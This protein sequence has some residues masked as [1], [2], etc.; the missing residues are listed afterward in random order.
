M[1]N[2]FY[3]YNYPHIKNKKTLV[4]ELANQSFYYST[5]IKEFVE[6]KE[7]ATENFHT[8]FNALY[9]EYQKSINYSYQLD[10]FCDIY[11]Q[12]LA[13][14]LMLARLDA[15][16][17]LDE[18]SLNY[19]QDIPNEYKLLKEFLS[20][21]YV[22]YDL[23]K[24]LRHTLINIG[25]NI[26]MIDTE[27]I[28][29]EFA[30][31][32]EGKQHIAV[33]LYEDFLQEYDK[34][35]K[36]KNRKESGVYYT[37]V[38]ATNFI[39]RGVNE[40]IKTRFNM[41][42]GY[43]AESVKVLDFACG[44]GTFLH[45]VFDEMLNNVVIVG[46]DPQ[47]P[48][49]ND[50]TVDDLTREIIKNKIVND[51]YGLELLFVPYIISHT[52]L[53]RFLKEHG[54][55]LKDKER[56]GIY[57]ANTLDI[58]QHS[59]SELLPNLKK[60]YEKAMDIKSRDEILAI[61]GNP[62]YF[63][64]ISQAKKGLIDE[65]IKIYKKDLNEKNIVKLEDL[66]IK[67]I[68]FAEW[69]I[70]KQKQGVIG[71]ITNNTYLDG[72]ISRKMRKHLLET[73]D[74]IYI[75]NLHGNARRKEPDKNI[76]DVMIGV[77]IIFLVKLPKRANKKVVRYF[78]TLDNNLTTRPQKLDFLDNTKF[79]KV[80]WKTL[81]PTE[82][83]YWFIEK[84]F[85]LQKK[86]NKFLKVKNIFENYNCGFQTKNDDFTIKYIEKQME[87]IIDDCKNMS[88][89][90]IKIKY[91]LLETKYWTMKYAQESLES[92][93]FDK[94]FIKPI[95]Y[96]AFDNRFTV[97]CE[98]K[99]FIERPTYNTLK[100]LKK[101]NKG[102]CFSRQLFS[103]DTWQDV[104]I[105]DKPVDIHAICGLTYVA[106]LYLYQDDSG[107][108]ETAEK[109]PNFTADFSKFI[110]TLNFRPNPEKI[111]AYIYAVLH[112]PIYRKKYIEF[113]KIDFPAV[114]FTT[115]KTIFEKYAKLGQRL[116]DLH[117]LKE[118]S[119]DNSIKVKGDVGESFTIDKIV[120][121]NETLYLH[122][123]DNKRITFE[124]ITQAI[125]DFEIG[126]YKPIDKWLKYRKKD[127]V[128][129]GSKD[130]QHIKD[131]AIAI[132]QTI[133]IMSEIEELGEEYLEGV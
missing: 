78:S 127:K 30:K 51:I 19:L 133:K 95:Q 3:S 21:A 132:K 39:T 5:A 103:G 101:E 24:P 38:E 87:T 93:N 107:A 100:H 8:K 115:D 9:D 17:D 120:Y 79:K 32:G 111:L 77:S 86:Y 94:N 109:I 42:R 117:L 57:L 12:S 63:S 40:L 129:L 119:N 97:L 82:P 52:M 37:P 70:E 61:I 89:E 59:I 121:E 114:P 22:S 76:F 123:T 16:N 125:Y 106:P 23:P 11:A 99:G 80:H 18:E 122:T 72:L 26:N 113:L 96:K 34:L 88:I 55:V 27:A 25:K 45:S 85:S 67:F 6:A 31:I 10:D 75:V 104:F 102:L 118:K 49:H 83:D 43:L 91:N 84:D 4:A 20:Q 112:S 48:N 44:T 90:K 29:K 68:R 66:Y 130:L 13:Y 105:T 64:G 108:F 62:P 81:E 15:N 92:I 58:S 116:I 14:G 98:K 50:D 33:F 128:L 7:N 36:T 56:L 71:I 74:E 131:M 126:S 65:E 47:S 54:I 69:K 41:P 1:L 35:K 124:S 110:K 73:F 53:T 60:E 46:P 28:Q 2:D